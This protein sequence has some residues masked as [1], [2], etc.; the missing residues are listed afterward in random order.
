[1]KP[2]RV[3]ISVVW[4]SSILA[5]IYAILLDRLIMVFGY[6]LGAATFLII[7]VVTVKWSVRSLRVLYRFATGKTILQ[8]KWTPVRILLGDED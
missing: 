2:R 4:Y 1:M 7:T 6:L 5:A 8:W 3:G